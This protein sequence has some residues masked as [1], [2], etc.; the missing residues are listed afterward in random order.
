MKVIATRSWMI[1]NGEGLHRK[2]DAWAKSERI[3]IVSADASTVVMNGGSVGKATFLSTLT[4][5]RLNSTS[6]ALRRAMAGF[7]SRPMLASSSRSG[8]SAHSSTGSTRSG[9]KA[10]YSAWVQRSKMKHLHEAGLACRPQKGDGARMF[11]AVVGRM[12]G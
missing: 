11:P 10:S 6:S 5:R 9:S 7:A 12:S 8:N 2:L 3:H 4:L 1:A